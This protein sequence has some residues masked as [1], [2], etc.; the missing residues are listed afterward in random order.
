MFNIRKLEAN[1][2]SL[3]DLLRAGSKFTSNQYCMPALG[4]IL[5]DKHISRY[6][7]VEKKIHYLCLERTLIL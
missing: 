3:L 4:L 1:F 7:K 2:G 5:L 6:K